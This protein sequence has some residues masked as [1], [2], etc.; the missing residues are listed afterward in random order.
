ML[1]NKLFRHWTYQI[2]FPGTMLREKYEAFKRLLECD[3]QAHDLMA[4]MQELTYGKPVDQA[5]VNILYG[6]LSK[7]VSDMIDCLLNIAPVT[8]LALPEY[9]KKTDFYI[10]LVLAPLEPDFSPPFVMPLSEIN[11][12]DAASF[13]LV[14]PKSARLSGIGAGLGL[15]I[16]HGFVVTTK[17]FNYFIESN[18][19][20]TLINEHLAGIDMKRPGSLSS[21]SRQL[22]NIVMSSQVPQVVQDEIFSA[23][24]ALKK[25]TGKDDA[26]I[27]VRSSAVS[28]D[29]KASFAGQYLTLLNVKD[30]EIID[31]YKKV[32]ASKYSSKALYYRINKGFSD[33]ETPMAV[34]VVEM[35]DAATSG[36]VA[37]SDLEQGNEDVLNIYFIPGMGGPLVSGE[38]SAD[39]MRIKK[40]IPMQVLERR[41]GGIT[42]V[43]SENE[44]SSRF[45]LDDN[46]A[47][48]LARFAL[49]IE[50]LYSE[51]QEIEWCMDGA[52]RLFFLQSR[53]LVV[54][55]NTERAAYGIR[56]EAKDNS[57]PAAILVKG[58]DRAS[59]GK[60]SGKVF[61]IA[62]LSDLELVPDGAVL[63][64]ENALPAYA[65][66]LGKI[67]AV[68]TDRGSI[69]GHL[70]MV[71]REFHVP[72]IVNT[73]FATKTLMDGQR[74]TV[75]A[76]EGI[77]Y[78]G[79]E[80]P[81]ARQSHSQPAW[82]AGPFGKRLNDA[83]GYIVPLRLID[84][85]QPSFSPQAC[86]SLHDI[87]RFVHEKAMSEMFLTGATRRGA[88]VYGA[89]RF[90]SNIPLTLYVLDVGGGLC[91]DAEETDK[92]DISMVCSRPML[93]FWKGIAHPDINWP[94]QGNFD[95][96]AFGDDVLA[97]G[98]A[99]KGSSAFAS[100]AVISSDYM[101]ISMKFGY[102]FAILD[103]MC[104][105]VADENYIM[106]R[107]A[108]GGGTLGGRLLR[109]EFLL[110]VMGE[111]GFATT[112]KGDLLDARIERL[113]LD[114]IEKKLV[115]TGSLL[116]VT[117]LMDLIF[118]DRAAV[119]R[120]AREFM[121][122]NMAL[123][124]GGDV[125]D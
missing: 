19:I 12:N 84:P 121:S 31:A 71:A 102:H 79:I 13:S 24:D 97:G 21:I 11:F 41:H 1:F 28:E 125:L 26:R 83:L 42:A 81:G 91:A 57:S 115:I 87:I 52:G 2:F 100:Y 108:G 104:G 43:V 114:G 113:D 80:R 40:T 68:V 45:Y 30:E 56:E 29:S 72:A 123:L 78:E 117:R 74:V 46:A 38:A 99:G 103:A 22:I 16:P 5:A 98:I 15:M 107:F 33:V 122:G 47:L 95:W 25:G 101:N 105:E 44:R 39:A 118:K 109:L 94:E 76:D 23:F 116:G 67:S 69:A 110:A 34:L 10:R 37:T 7:S 85:S 75:D 92:V 63:V 35:I 88:R 4:G 49:E 58:G 90:E 93:A 27:A 86:R 9:F 59:C 50:R 6:R 82:M 53:P 20:R 32:I 8:Y 66:V 36:V 62:R 111:L 73:V 55:S 124:R 112:V 119:E 89:K 70:A 54:E 96:R 18:N 60:A 3:R 14:G 48:M 64:A 120:C 65:E 77:V 17:A 106:F 51:P 61:K